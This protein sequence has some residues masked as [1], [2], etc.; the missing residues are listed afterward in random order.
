[1][2]MVRNLVFLLCYLLTS[3]VSF[4]QAPK[5]NPRAHIFKVVDAHTLTPLREAEVSFESKGRPVRECQRDQLGNPTAELD[6]GRY[7]FHV[8]VDGYEQLDT[9][10]RLKSARENRYVVF[11]MEKEI[12]EDSE[13]EFSVNTSGNVVSMEIEDKHREKLQQEIQAEPAPLPA[14][15]PPRIQGSTVSIDSIGVFD[16]KD[17][18]IFV[19]PV[20]TRAAKKNLDEILPGKGAEPKKEEEPKDNTVMAGKSS[21]TF[22]DEVQGQLTFEDSLMINDYNTSLSA[23][24]FM[25]NNIVFLIDRSISMEGMGRFVLLKTA[26][27][28]LASKL[29]DEDLVSAV[30]YGTTAEVLFSGLEGN[31]IDKVANGL[32]RVSCRG[33]SNVDLGIAQAYKIAEEHHVAGGNNLIILATDG[34]IPISMYLKQFIAEKA[35]DGYKLSVVGIKNE[36]YAEGSM[37]ELAA[38]GGGDYINMQSEEKGYKVLMQEIKKKSF[39]K[40]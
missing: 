7:L 34:G 15:S 29:R 23:D 30:V 2:D 5:A 27:I 22:L 11:R 26:V 14:K 35:D 16:K 28:K 33:A 13:V 4:G 36:L 12:A 6:S 9:I 1:M 3:T 32:N 25:V 8:V 24:N 40:K 31:E 17:E 21:G 19:S 10:V 20:E 39:K 37:K 38:L 18:Q